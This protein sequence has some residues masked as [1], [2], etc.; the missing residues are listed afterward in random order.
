MRFFKIC[1]VLILVLLFMVSC[2][3]ENNLQDTN[4]DISNNTYI[5][6]ADEYIKNGQYD[7]P[8]PLT[9]LR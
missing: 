6:L 8:N 9:D 3:N 7:L 1:T 4:K 2:Q 5:E